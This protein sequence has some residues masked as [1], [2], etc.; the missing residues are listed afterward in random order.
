MFSGLIMEVG[1]V[2][3]LGKVNKLQQIYLSGFAA[4]LL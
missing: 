3:L 1:T 2:A 4:V